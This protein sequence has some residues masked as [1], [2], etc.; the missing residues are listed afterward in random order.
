M[1]IRRILL[2]IVFVLAASVVVVPGATAD[3]FA[4]QPCPDAA[5]PNTSTC[6]AGTA[7]VP[8]SLQFLLADGAGC[9][10][11]L[12]T[13][14]VSSGT[15]PPGLSLNSGSGA[16]SGT[17]TEAGSFKFFLKVEYPV[18]TDPACNGGFSDHE[19][20]IPIN[21][22]VPK[23]VIGPEQSGVPIS[24]VGAPFSLP[25]TS[26][27][28]DAKT[29]SLV[30]GAGTL[31]PGLQLGST[32]GVISGTPSVAG[33]YYFTVRAV[34]DSDSQRSDTKALGI[35][36]R[37][38]VTI[39]APDL[40]VSSTGVSGSE[41]GVRVSGEFAATGG[42]GTFTWSVAGALPP[43]VFFDAATGALDGRPTTAG[44]YRFVVTATD[45]ER[46]VA[47]YNASL[48]VAPRL[49]LLAQRIPAAQVGRYLQL[50]LR[51]N[52]G[53]G[54]M[55][56]RVKRGPLPRGISFDRETATFY[57]TPG[58]A[59]RY[60]IGVEVVDALGVKATKTLVLV[61]RAAKKPAKRTG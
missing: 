52:G 43:G 57:G 42:T 55:S 22:G 14:S 13:W 9:G 1:R 44:R 4:D 35:T 19:Y 60:R 56:W 58:R 47:T 37:D 17:P 61:I 27:L 3:D 39:I 23:L 59:R 29:W 28:T 31:P 11:G 38:R 8:Y 40:G 54:P 6:P 10:P 16:V 24:T 5:G 2:I 26:N 20:T 7:G 53:V 32:D 50:R 33:T 45:S 34:L 49:A 12:T 15:F 48:M 46:R 41:V 36:V 51:S 30:D 25:M 18:L 21:P